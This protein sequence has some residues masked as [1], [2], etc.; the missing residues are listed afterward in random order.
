MSQYR[1]E[2]NHLSDCINS[3]LVC[4]TYEVI[5]A[6]YSALVGSLVECWQVFGAAFH[7]KT[8]QEAVRRIQGSGRTTE[9]E[10]VSLA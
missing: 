2:G 7:E 4:K 6:V 5:L 10:M 8:M 9:V 3:N 1:N